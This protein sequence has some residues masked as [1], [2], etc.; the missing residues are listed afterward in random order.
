MKK[1]VTL[2]SVILVLTLKSQSVKEKIAD[3]RFG[4]LEYA[5]A[6]EVYEELAAGKHAKTK[7]FIRAGESNFMVGDYKRAQIYYDKAYSLNGG[8][9]D[10]DYYNYYQVLKYNGNYAKAGEVFNK[11]NDNQYKLI[12][13]NISKKKL[14]LEELKKDSGNYTIKRLEM[15]SEESDF[16]PYVV[17]NEMYFLS[18][19]RNTSMSNRKYAWDN[20]YYLDVYK[21]YIDGNSVKGEERVKEGMKT[22]YHE[23]PLSF[24]KDGKTQFICRNNYVNN[25]ITK[26]K[27]SRV[28]LK[29]YSRKLEGE[30]WSEW[31]ELPFNS[32][33]YTC[34]HPAISSDGKTL[35][36]ASDMPGT[37]GGLDL[38]IS[39]IDDKGVWSKP[40]NL[41]QSVNSEGRECFPF[42]FEDEVLFY[43]SDGKIG[44]GGLDVFY[45][46]ASEDLYFEAQNLGYPINTQYDDFGF[47]AKT[48]TQ[49]YFSSNRGGTSTRDDIYSFV[50]KRPIIS[51]AI[52]FVALDKESKEIIP[53][54]KIALIDEAGK[55]SY[56]GIT[57]DK[58]EIKFNVIPGKG[59]KVKTTKDG[60]KESTTIVREEDISAL[61]GKKKELLVE[62]KIIG[63]LCLIAD[64][65][66][67]S[68]IEG[69]KVTITDAFN[70]KNVLSFTTDKNG[71]FRHIYKDK[72]VGDDLS[73]IVKLEK[74]GYIAKTQPIDITI[75]KEGYILLHEYMNT[76]MYKMKLGADLGKMI[77]LKPIYF[78]LGKFSIRPDAATELNKVADLMKQNPAITIELG[79]HTDCRGSAA[80]NMLLSDKRA[81]SS[82]AYIVSKGISKTRIT[83][84]GYGESKLVN[85]C[86]CE[87]NVKPN[88]TEEEHAQNRRTE[89]KIT[90][91]AP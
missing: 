33:E 69:V 41:G 59:Y 18:A 54:A 73:Y 34:E 4:N 63:L 38:W 48:N 35:Y 81:K 91:I 77:D 49:G 22:K 85:G 72:K 8:M 86:A 52:E 50:S 19:R 25:K 17:G 57:N 11:I 80:S 83:G 1:I 32:N 78:D 12:R 30:K 74:E 79:S 5:S 16:S 31:A 13:D 87:G 7:Y 3:K 27:D 84:N 39:R 43:S 36:F 68:P 26:S 89:F 46:V 40:E 14:D 62:K 2:L 60:Y 10:F 70:P 53:N 9:T 76:K 42:I 66:D 47:F 51:S 29:I 88:C 20:S 64:A 90:K 58:G 61:A 65:D 6:K 23:G 82:A 55:P 24:T 67:L 21:G 75:K 15:N 56:E 45:T 37:L 44:L 28:N 71:D